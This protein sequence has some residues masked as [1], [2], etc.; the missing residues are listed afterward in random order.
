ML[1]QAFLKGEW[2]RDREIVKTIP[3]H[4]AVDFR[5]TKMKIKIKV[6]IT[7]SVLLPS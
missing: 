2:G 7:H 3:S 5:S 4:F 1:I 6:K